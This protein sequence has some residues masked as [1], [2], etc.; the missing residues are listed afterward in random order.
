[1]YRLLRVN[2]ISVKFVLKAPARAYLFQTT[3]DNIKTRPSDSIIIGFDLYVFRTALRES[4]LFLNK[5]WD[6]S[7][8]QAKILKENIS[9]YSEI[10]ISN[11]NIKDYV[12]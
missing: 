12:H 6:F 2:Y 10:K 5:S 3:V 1:M 7:G 4:R 8:M 11:K 9:I